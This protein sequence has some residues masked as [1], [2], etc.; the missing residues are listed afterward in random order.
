MDVEELSE[1]EQEWQSKKTIGGGK[2]RYINVCNDVPQ[3]A[4]VTGAP[5]NF[6]KCDRLLRAPLDMAAASTSSATRQL[7]APLGDPNA[8]NPDKP[9]IIYIY[10]SAERE[11]G[12]NNKLRTRTREHPHTHFLNPAHPKQC[13]LKGHLTLAEHETSKATGLALGRVD[14]ALTQSSARH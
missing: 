3:C 12:E 11:P 2:G 4:I 1:P 8:D 13:V 7:T 14:P 10:T 9:G 5:R 6:D